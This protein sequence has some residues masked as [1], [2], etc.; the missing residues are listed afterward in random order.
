VTTTFALDVVMIALLAATIAYCVI[1]ERK[2]RALRADQGA[3][4]RMIEAFGEATARAEHSIARL[5]AASAEHGVR[6]DEKAATAQAIV[7][8]LAFLTERAERLADRLASVRAP[9]APASPPASAARTR[10]KPAPR[11]KGPSIARLPLGIEPF[12][13][14]AANGKDD[15]AVDGARSESAVERDLRR[16]IRAAQR[17]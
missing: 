6:L 8:E 4:M 2:L 16:A 9:T 13:E 12:P 3:F 11:P 5:S 7:D 1:L 17:G 14:P 10:A 15:E